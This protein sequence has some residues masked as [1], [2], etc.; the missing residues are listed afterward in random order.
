MSNKNDLTVIKGGKKMSKKDG[1]F[2]GGLKVIAVTAV[3]AGLYGYK[4]GKGRGY[5]IGVRDGYVSASNEFIE[6]MRD[7]KQE[8]SEIKPK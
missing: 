3:G 2:K 6:V 1:N 5:D 4:L 8:I 7:L